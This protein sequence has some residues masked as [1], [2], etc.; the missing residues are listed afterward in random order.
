VWGFKSISRY[1]GVSEAMAPR[2]VLVTFVV[3]GRLTV[4]YRDPGGSPFVL[5]PDAL[6]FESIP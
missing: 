6:C 1:I 3:R 2:Y 4:D 5:P